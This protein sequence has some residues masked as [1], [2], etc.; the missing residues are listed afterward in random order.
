MARFDDACNLLDAADAS[1]PA[2]ETLYGKSL[3]SREIYPCLLIRIKNFLENLRSALDYA[4]RE[5][6]ERCCSKAKGNV[7]GKRGDAT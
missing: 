3:A 2:I 1:L 5:I 7:G 4:A 6:F